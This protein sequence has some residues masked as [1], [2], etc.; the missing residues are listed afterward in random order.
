[1]TRLVVRILVPTH[2]ADVFPLFVEKLEAEDTAV[3]SAA[4]SSSAA[5]KTVCATVEK[6]GV[7]SVFF[8]TF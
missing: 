4:L 1:M 7:D 2:G 5:V 8:R 6:V 3:W